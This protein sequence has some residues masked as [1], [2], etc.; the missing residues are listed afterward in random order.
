MLASHK[1]VKKKIS[2]Y[3]YFDILYNSGKLRWKN[4]YSRLMISFLMYVQCFQF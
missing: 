3:K 1:I 2:V 4:K